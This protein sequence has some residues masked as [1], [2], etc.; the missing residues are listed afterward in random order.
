[1]RLKIDSLPPKFPASPTKMPTSLI[2]IQP[3]RAADKC[4]SW[5]WGRVYADLMEDPTSKTWYI[6]TRSD[7]KNFWFLLAIARPDLYM[8]RKNKEHIP[9][10]HLA[11]AV[12]YMMKDDHRTYIERF[13]MNEHTDE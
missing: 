9:V 2:K 8:L 4:L 10:G 5:F 7:P 11:K 13:M 12:R 6:D 3:Q 1:M